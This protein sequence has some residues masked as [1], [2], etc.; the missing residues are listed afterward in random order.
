MS[1]YGEIFENFFKTDYGKK[2]LKTAAE[3]KGPVQDEI[4]EAHPE[5]GV[6]TEVSKP[7]TVTDEYSVPQE[8]VE[9]DA[10][11]ETV[12]EVATPCEQVARKG[13]PTISQGSEVRS[14][15][16]VSKK[17][18]TKSPCPPTGPAHD[19][20]GKGVGMPG[21]K[22][23]GL[24]DG[25]RG[26]GKRW[27]VKKDKKAFIERLLEL[28]NK[29]DS[30]GLHAEASVLD[31]MACEVAGLNKSAFFHPDQYEKE[32]EKVRKEL[33]E[34]EAELEALRFVVEAKK[35][36]SKSSACR[37]KYV[38]EEGHFKGKA[39]TGERFDNC[40]KYQKC[41]G[42]SQEAAERICAAIKKRKYGGLGEDI[43]TA[44]RKPEPG[45]PIGKPEGAYGEPK[46][47]KDDKRTKELKY[48]SKKKQEKSVEEYM[49]EMPGR[50]T[51]EEVEKLLRVTEP[52]REDL[53]AELEALRFIV[54]AKKGKSKSSKCREKYLSEEGH[55]KGKAGTGER[56]DNCVKYQKCLG[57]S[58]EAAK[59]ICAAIKKR[60][61]GGLDEDTVVG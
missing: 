26:G 8:N 19:G 4:A 34:K 57:K 36:D 30:S 18:S 54:E 9:G 50:Q 2:L 22:R 37:K 46:G 14:F 48:P 53:T 3:E 60:K 5:G 12:K 61:Y 16:K 31:E 45:E 21:G 42:K 32:S 49:R 56:F 17:K 43:V 39:G 40:V 35:G 52:Y 29:L 25:E 41:L 10:H 59:R 47:P 24:E 11:V 23:R 33:V 20:R 1:N 55:F 27:K 13:P 6:D 58:E 28:A 15:T 7:G 38:S 44:E 51:E